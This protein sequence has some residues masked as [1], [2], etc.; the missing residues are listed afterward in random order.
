MPSPLD[1]IAWTP[2][3]IKGSPEDERVKRA[4]EEFRKMAK[5]TTMEWYQ[6]IFL[7]VANLL[8]ESKEPT[9]D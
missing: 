1:E 3:E 4:I 6:P 9:D 8:E 2:F 7:D 5:D